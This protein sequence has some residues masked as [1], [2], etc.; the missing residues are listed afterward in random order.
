MVKLSSTNM[1]TEIIL[2]IEMRDSLLCFA[3]NIAEAR[4]SRG[5]SQEEMAKR[6]LMSRTTYRAIE[7]G[8]PGVSIGHYLAVLD[9]LG[10]GQGV[11]ELAAPHLDEDGRRMRRLKGKHE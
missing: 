7:S 4:V 1:K 10:L 2:S 5:W 9:V 3:R 11:K 8:S 6:A